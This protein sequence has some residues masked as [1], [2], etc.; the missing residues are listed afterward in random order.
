MMSTPVSF[1]MMHT[2]GLQSADTSC[3]KMRQLK[4]EDKQFVLPADLLLSV[5]DVSDS[6]AFDFLDCLLLQAC[7]IADTDFWQLLFRWQADRLVFVFLTDDM[8]VFSASLSVNDMSSPLSTVLSS[9]HSGWQ[10]ATRS[11]SVDGCLQSCVV[12]PSAFDSFETEDTAVSL[13]PVHNVRLLVSVLTQPS[14]TRS[15]HSTTDASCCSVMY[16]WIWRIKWLSAKTAASTGS[17]SETHCNWKA[18]SKLHFHCFTGTLQQHGRNVK[19]YTS[20]YQ[21]A[22]HWLLVV[23]QQ[24]Q[25]VSVSTKKSQHWHYSKMPKT[26]CFQMSVNRQAGPC[27]NSSVVLHVVSSITLTT[28]LCV[29]KGCS[30]TKKPTTGKGGVRYGG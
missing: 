4:N 25:T 5:V 28:A 19:L 9:M 3:Q 6:T 22:L 1:W 10:A 27:T 12:G 30:A 11:T 18:S 7:F 21:S 8:S 2:T 24:V 16:T 13:T 14:S 20:T 17:Q 26:S 29:D 15:L 23:A